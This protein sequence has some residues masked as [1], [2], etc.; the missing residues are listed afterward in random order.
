MAW[1]ANGDFG[2]TS[3]RGQRDAATYGTGF[4]STVLLTGIRGMLGQHLARHIQRVAPETDIIGTVRNLSN[5]R[6]EE[7]LFEAEKRMG[8]SSK[9]RGVLFDTLDLNNPTAIEGLIKRHHPDFMINCAGM[10]SV[11]DSWLFAPA[12][13]QV[14]AVAVLHQL[15]AIHKWSPKTRYLNVGSGEENDPA[16]VRYVQADASMYPQSP[17]AISKRTAHD[18]VRVW[19]EVHG[20]FAVQPWCFNFESQLRNPRYISRK[21]A[22]GVA[23]I[24]KAIRGSE[25]FA[26]ILVGN[27]ESRRTW[28]SADDVA[29]GIW[30]SLNQEKPVDYVLSAPET[31][32]VRELIEQAFECAGIAG[33]WQGLPGTTDERF[34]WCTNAN[35]LANKAPTPLVRV[36]A[37][38]LRPSDSNVLWGDSTRARNELGW[39]TTVSFERLIGEMVRTDMEALE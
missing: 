23:R 8:L 18:F 1:V 2:S 31:H 9:T 6:Q 39:E 7:F 16:V 24:E 33:M 27:L 13:M 4:L 15:A 22:M 28:Q 10:A 34:I 14:N 38:F 25:P 35:H 20:L 21:V 37:A 29:D 26:P 19:R 12:Y 30:R 32:T 17:Y 36:D 5:L 11:S 3:G